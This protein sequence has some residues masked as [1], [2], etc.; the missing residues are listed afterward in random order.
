MIPS[1][2]QVRSAYKNILKPHDELTYIFVRAAYFYAYRIFSGAQYIMLWI[3]YPSHVHD[4]GRACTT[5]RQQITSYS[6][7]DFNHAW[8]WQMRWSAG[9][10]SAT[11][12]PG[13]VWVS[14]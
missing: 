9:A 4:I 3:Y 12:R 6:L 10:V 8:N 2:S 1:A 14:W 13:K 7:G 11:D 5:I